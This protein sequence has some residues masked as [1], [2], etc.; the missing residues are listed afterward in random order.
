MKI[1]NDIRIA[2][3][4]LSNSS[5]RFLKFVE[6]NTDALKASSFNKLLD[7]NDNL[8]VLHPWPSFINQHI[9]NKMKEASIRIF[10]LIKSIPKRMFANDPYKINQFFEIPVD[11]IKFQLDGTNEKHIENLLARGDFILSPTGLKC[12]E[13]NV[14]ANLG[15]WELPIWESL[16]LKTP[17]ISK[18]LKEY[19]LKITNKNLLATLFDHLI[20]VALDKS[21]NH[22][23][24][25]NIALGMPIKPGGNYD[26]M[27]LYMNNLYK[28]NLQLRNNK[29][30]G[31]IILCDLNHLDLIDDFIFHKDLKIHS[32]IE[33]H[34]GLITT[35]ISHAFK[36]G[37]VCLYNGPIT[38]LL[39]NKLNLALLSEYEDSDIFSIEEREAIKKY[40][41]W[42][43]KIASYET[44]YGT[45]K[46][47]LENFILSNK[48]KLVIKPSQGSGGKG[49]YIGR[50]ASQ[51]KWEE[52][53]KTAVKM[54]NI[55]V[56]EYIEPSPYLY[57]SGENGCAVHDAVW[58]FFILGSR[59]GGGWVRVL[60]KEKSNGVINCH[61]GATVSVI[62]EFLE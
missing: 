15:G 42:T 1:T 7:W 17:A 13:Y 11:I 51:K 46:V 9:K 47:K 48:Q 54:K 27:E 34:H 43:R 12:L 57:Q 32:I 44:S 55:L 37:N 2:H 19:G 5:I 35:E 23:T 53:V 59:Y 31:K 60:P 8:H 36:L 61:Q 49:I 41:P 52:L 33:M 62:F 10:N 28:K 6:N 30:K 14:S 18:F 26:E 22:D 25:I 56:Q 45:S 20:T 21:F 58:G 3:E 38:G 50:Y 40:I 29:L 4:N 24:E 39:S 16:Y